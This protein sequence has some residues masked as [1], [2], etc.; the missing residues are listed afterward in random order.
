MES[1]DTIAQYHREWKLSDERRYLLARTEK[2]LQ[3][4]RHVKEK[5]KKDFEEAKKQYDNSSSIQ[6][7]LNKANE[8]KISSY[9]TDINRLELKLR[10]MTEENNQLQG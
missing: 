5:L 1:E 3:D 8:D 9:K 2:V 7:E 4:E 6:A 10:E